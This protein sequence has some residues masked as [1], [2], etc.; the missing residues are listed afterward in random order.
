MSLAISNYYAGLSTSAVSNTVHASGG[1]SKAADNAGCS[2]AGD[3][4]GYDPVR[5][6][7]AGHLAAS[8]LLNSLIL[9]TEDNV[10]HLAAGLSRISA[11]FSPMRA[12]ARSR[13]LNS[14]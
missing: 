1:G 8:G 2:T 9:P 4:A 5:L 13:P 6:S 11:I 10:R 12:S 7:G 3:A 14:T